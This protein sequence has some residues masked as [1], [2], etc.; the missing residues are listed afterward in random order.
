VLAIPLKIHVRLRRAIERLSARLGPRS[1][2][3][4]VK[5]Y[6]VDEITLFLQREDVDLI[7]SAASGHGGEGVGIE[8]GAEGTV[9]EAEV[10]CV[11]LHLSRNVSA[12]REARLVLV[13]VNPFQSRNVARI[14][15]P[16]LLGERSSSPAALS[17]QLHVFEAHVDGGRLP[18]AGIDDGH[19]LQGL[20]N[21][22]E[23]EVEGGEDRRDHA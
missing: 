3:K 22:E 9:F 6:P 18:R 12:E 11:P 15:R 20:T 23:G 17:I 19:V 5:E 1:K 4:G 7:I 14:E 21:R 10:W 16:E 2:C 8:V 13:S